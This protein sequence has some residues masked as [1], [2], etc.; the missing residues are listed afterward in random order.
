MHSV[1]LRAWEGPADARRCIRRESDAAKDS[2]CICCVA[3]RLQDRGEHGSAEKGRCCPGA[4]VIWNLLAG[5][6]TQ[7]NA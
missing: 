2:S 1:T 3:A 6:S 7:D 4:V 5:A